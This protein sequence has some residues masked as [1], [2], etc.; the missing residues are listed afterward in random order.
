VF[1]RRCAFGCFC[2]VV[3]LYV[4]HQPEKAAHTTT[5]ILGGLSAAADALGRFADAF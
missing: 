5:A 4:L 3:V 2:L 1:F